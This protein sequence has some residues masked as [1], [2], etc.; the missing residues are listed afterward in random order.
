MRSV[1]WIASYPKSGNTWVRFI[2]ANLMNPRLA[3]S[4]QVEQIIPDVHAGFRE[5]DLAGDGVLHVKT[6]LVF[7]DQMPFRDASSAAVYIVRNPLDVLVS[8]FNYRKLLVG[9]R[10]AALPVQQRL[11]GYVE[12]FIR[13]GGD[14]EWIYKGLGTW[15]ENVDSWLGPAMPLR[16]LVIRYE[17]LRERPHHVIA[18]LAAFLGLAPTADAIARVVAKTSFAAMRRMEEREIAK[19]KRG[20]FMNPAFQWSHAQGM[21]FMHQGRIG[22]YREVLSDEQ[23]ER[24]LDRFGPPMRRL[25]YLD[26]REPQRIAS[27]KIAAA[28]AAAE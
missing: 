20:F 17:T 19:A 18:E 12:D 4:A 15:A 2:V 7:G 3:S 8:N 28:H 24:A 11:L 16:R 21:R 25:G 14:A 27:P 1:T 26:P 10:A 22:A 5:A 6:H 23:L 13:Y 9:S